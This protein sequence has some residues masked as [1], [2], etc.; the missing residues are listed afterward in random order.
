[1][2]APGDGSKEWRSGAQSLKRGAR[3]EIVETGRSREAGGKMNRALP[4]IFCLAAVRGCA[5]R[6]ANGRP[7]L[8][9]AGSNGPGPPEKPRIRHVLTV[10]GFKE[11]GISVKT[12]VFGKSE[13]RLSR[14]RGGCDGRGRQDRRG[15]RRDGGRPPVCTGRKTVRRDFPPRDRRGRNARGGRIRRRVAALR[16]DSSG[17]DDPRLRQPGE[18]LRSIDGTA[19]AK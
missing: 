13:G 5:S 9:R 2:R 6:W 8:R 7:G 1:V 10:T 14:P 4:L 15:R 3:I 11:E 17:G 19:T 12:L 16:V 18:F